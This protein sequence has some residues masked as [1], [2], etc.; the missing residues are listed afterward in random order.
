MFTFVDQKTWTKMCISALFV[1]GKKGEMIHM[2]ICGKTDK[3]QNIHVCIPMT[4]P[5]LLRHAMAYINPT[6]LR[7]GR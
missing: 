6:M 1:I 2:L 5:K 3:V 7:K 4:M